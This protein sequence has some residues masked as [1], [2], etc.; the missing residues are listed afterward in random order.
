[1]V[2]ASLLAV[3]GGVVRNNLVPVERVLENTVVAAETAEVD[4]FLGCWRVVV[5]VGEFDFDD[6]VRFA[7][8]GDL[9]VRYFVT[10]S[11]MV[12]WIE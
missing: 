9:P 10:V 7:Q 6:F 11:S 4:Q 8:D 3:H 2:E 1:M 5:V 12:R